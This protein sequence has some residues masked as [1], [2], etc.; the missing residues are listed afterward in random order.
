[1]RIAVQERFGIVRGGGVG[2]TTILK[3]VARACGAFGRTIHMMALA[4]RA[5]VRISEA[6]GSHASPSPPS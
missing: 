6:T 5:A 1:M 4:G 2:K 3:A